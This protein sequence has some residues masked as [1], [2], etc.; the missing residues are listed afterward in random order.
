MGAP[1][2]LL[3][4]RPLR[5]LQGQ[6]LEDPVRQEE[7]DLLCKQVLEMD[8]ESARLTAGRDH[9]R[10][11]LVLAAT[12]SASAAVAAERALAHGA[13][14]RHGRHGDGCTFGRGPCTCGLADELA[15][16]APDPDDVSALGE[17]FLWLLRQE[18]SGDS[19]DTP[20]QQGVLVRAAGDYARRWKEHACRR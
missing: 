13:L 8:E 10:A 20:D 12:S 1:G 17:A 19:M 14:V 4:G 5:V 7:H 11:L 15:R 2:A 6:G 16:M 3:P 18:T 9:R